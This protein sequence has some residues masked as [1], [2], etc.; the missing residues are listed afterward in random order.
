MKRVI[1][2]LALVLFIQISYS[3]KIEVDKGSGL[4]KVDG[5]ESFYLIKKKKGLGNFDLSLQNLAKEEL[6]YLTQKF[7]GSLP[8]NERPNSIDLPYYQFTFT[9]TANTLNL[10]ADAINQKHIAKV[11][12]NAH[13]IKDNKVDPKAEKAFLASNH[14]TIFKDPNSDRVNIVVNTTTP[15]PIGN[16]NI[17]LKGSNIYNNSEFIGTFKKIT[18]NSGITT[19]SLYKKDQSKVAI[20]KHND[21]DA[22]DDWVVTTEPDNK[23]TQVLY[24]PSSPVE[25][26][27]KFLAE[28]GI[29]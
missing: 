28:K 25:M 21:K 29:F 14:G 17:S 24:N 5:A 22:N 19:L 6:A 8:P 27:I 15:N 7:T 23:T 10:F 26:L 9:E 12:V 13:L 2:V 18:D 16:A 20:A 3:Q 1:S 11:I 4:V